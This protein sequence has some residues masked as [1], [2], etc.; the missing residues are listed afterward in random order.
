MDWQQLLGELVQF[1]Q[2]AAPAAWEAVRRQAIVTGVQYA[3]VGFIFLILS[4][5]S[6]IASWKDYKKFGRWDSE[7][8]MGVWLFLSIIG[9]A[10]AAILFIV[11][12]GRFINP[13]YYAIKLLIGYIQ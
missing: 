11:S 9:A 7:K 8:P 3:S 5:L 10:I 13:D 12:I 1:V 2:E 4:G 6:G